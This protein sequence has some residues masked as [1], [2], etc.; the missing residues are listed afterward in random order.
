MQFLWPI[1]NMFGRQNTNL[2]L[3]DVEMFKAPKSLQNTSNVTE[4]DFTVVEVTI[5]EVTTDELT[6]SLMKKL[7]RSFMNYC[8]Q[9]PL[10]KMF[11]ISLACY[12]LQNFINVTSN[13]ICI[14]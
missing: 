3:S 10:A 6:N 2:D 8:L 11:S 9:L 14:R 13:L 4:N 1:R 12:G 7:K 5:V